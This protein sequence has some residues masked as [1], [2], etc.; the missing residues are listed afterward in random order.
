[1]ADTT[2]NNE[3]LI[4]ESS[5][6]DYDAY[7]REPLDD[8][9]EL[10]NNDSPTIGYFVKNGHITEAFPESELRANNLM[11][12]INPLDPHVYHDPPYAQPFVAKLKN[13]TSAAESIWNMTSDID[14]IRIDAISIPVVRLNTMVLEWENIDALTITYTK[15]LPELTLIAKDPAGKF[16][17]SVRPG[18]NN[19]IQVIIMPAID[20]KYKKIS[21]PFYI[22]D[23]DVDIYGEKTTYTGILKHMPLI[24]QLL[25][26]ESIN[27]KACTGGVDPN[28]KCIDVN[29]EKPNMWQLFHEIAERAKLGFA[30]MPGLKD[31]NDHAVRNI[32]SQNYKEFL[33]YNLSIGGLD[34]KMIYDGWV[35]MYGYLVLV[36]VYKALHD[37]IHP[38]NLAL[39]AETGLHTHNS[40]YPDEK[41]SA[42]RRLLTNSNM[43]K[44]KSNLEIEEFYNTSNIGEIQQH[45]TLNTIYYFCPFGNHGMNNILPEQV[46]IQEDS[47]DG[48]YVEDYEVQ[49]YCG[50][51]FVGCEDFNISRQMEI[52]DAYLTKLRN[53]S[54]KL[55]IRLANPN[56]ALQRG[57]LVI[58]VR[59]RY[60]YEYKMRMLNSE[61]NLY[62]NPQ[63]KGFTPD[64]SGGE[65]DGIRNDDILYNDGIGVICAEDSGIYYID[66]MRFDYINGNEKIQQYLYLIKRDPLTSLS[67]LSTFDRAK[68]PD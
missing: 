65:V 28:D 4:Y 7:P 19:V 27:Y 36:D 68:A 45:G 16:G 34:E 57:T 21:L 63:V 17:L 8:Y 61:S 18:L 46:R 15:F 53:S 56:Y 20:G 10:D 43:T 51:S 13:T 40:K 14:N 12:P 62:P 29:T 55:T 50:W 38:N 24:Q 64:K 67:N 35:D 60:D 9:D 58:I 32:C 26:S 66:G 44:T 41:F 6:G 59:M 37:D 23:V 22:T 11:P 1:M 48:K 30:A 52:R 3:Q 31:Y 5:A 49:K 47:T 33:E 25:N 39:H 2:E 54:S 42:A